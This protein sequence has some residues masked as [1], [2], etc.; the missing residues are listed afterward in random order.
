MTPFKMP[1]T[2]SVIASGVKYFA[3]VGTARI[4]TAASRTRRPRPQRADLWALPLGQACRAGLAVS[5]NA[6]GWGDGMIEGQ[7]RRPDIKRRMSQ[8]WDTADASVA[9]KD[10]GNIET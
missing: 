8:S 6:L 3:P 5:A 9:A 2:A 7:L 10:L 1:I 4:R